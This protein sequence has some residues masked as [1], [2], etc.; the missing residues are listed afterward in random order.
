MQST[1]QRI[2]RSD[3][4]E[5]SMIVTGMHLL[6]EYGLTVSQIEA[7]GLP[8]TA[9][10]AVEEGLP[11]GALMAKNIGRMLIGLVEE[12][13][14]IRPNIVMV[15]G[16]RGEMLAGALGAIHLNIPVVHIHGGERSG[17]V[18]EPVRHAI[19]KLA[20]FPFCRYRREQIAARP[21]G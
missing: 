7:A 2:H 14:T 1:L 11:S 12:L 9:Q 21:H 4:L 18:D 15:L 20:H 5:L 19:S 3:L 17:T 13:E 8:V 6:P 10:I 16:D